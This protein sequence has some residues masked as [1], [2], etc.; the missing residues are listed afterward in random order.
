MAAVL[1]G[2]VAF[3]A[4]LAVAE[5]FRSDRLGEAAETSRIAPIDQSV[6]IGSIQPTSSGGY[7]VAILNGDGEEIAQTVVAS[8][9]TV[10]MQNGPAVSARP[11]DG[12]DTRV[13]GKT[14]D[15]LPGAPTTVA[16]KPA[17]AGDAVTIEA[18]QPRASKASEDK[19]LLLAKF[20]ESVH[21]SAQ[22]ALDKALNW[23]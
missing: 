8:N 2:A 19:I 21:Q 6:Q 7:Q 12:G 20:G 1:A 13:V 10:L 5:S 9:E 17:P 18:Y 14:S 11:V 3:T 22:R 15:R 4:P 16:T 23:I